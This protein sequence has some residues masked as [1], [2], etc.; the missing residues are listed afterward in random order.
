M[1]TRPEFSKQRDC[2][3]VTDYPVQSEVT[4]DMVW[5]SASHLTLQDDLYRVGIKYESCS[6]TYLSYE[7]PTK[8]NYDWKNSF[9]K[10]HDLE[11]F[12]GALGLA[13]EL[14][15]ELEGSKDVWVCDKLYQEYKALLKQ[16]KTVNPKLLIVIGKWSLFFLCRNVT[17]A[18]TISTYKEPRPFGGLTTYRSSMLEL[19][20]STQLKSILVIPAYP[21]VVIFK[22]PDRKVIYT[23]DLDKLGVVF[24]KLKGGTSLEHY[25]HVD[26]ELNYSDNYAYLM[27]ALE[28]IY[29]QVDSKVTKLAMDIETRHYAIDCI[30]LC[31]EKDVSL[32]IPFSSYSEPCLHTWEEEVNLVNKI[33][34]ILGHPNAKIVGQN[35]FYDSAYLSKFWLFDTCSFRDTMITNHVIYNYLPK[36]LDFLA[37]FY[38]D[39]YTYWKDMASHTIIPVTID[40]VDKLDEIRW[41]YNGLDCCYTYAIAY[42]QEEL[43]GQMPMKFLEFYKFQ[44]EDLTPAISRVMKRGVRVDLAKKQELYT[45]LKTLM[46][47]ARDKLCWLI[48]EEWN[49]NSTPQIRSIFID[50]LRVNPVINKKSLTSTF[51]SDAMLV[52]L[53]NYPDYKV[54]LI[55][56]LEYRSLK[57]FVS[58]FLGAEVDDDNRMRSSYNIAGTSTYRLAS[59]KNQFGTG[60]NLQNVPS[61]GKIDLRYALQNVYVA[62]EIDEETVVDS[63]EN[64]TSITKLPNCKQLFIPDEGYTF[65]DVDFAGAD[66]R[67]M[68]YSANCSYLIDIFEDP[69]KD[70]YSTM[71]SVYYGRIIHK[72]DKE[73]QIFK[74]IVHASNY[75]GHATTLS[76]KAGL[77]VHEVERVQK[78][79]FLNCPEIVRLQ[80]KIKREVKDRG[81]IENIFGARGYFLDYK[82]KMLYNKAVAW[83][84]SSPISILTNKGLVNIDKEAESLKKSIYTVHKI[85]PVEVLLQVHDSLAGQYKSSDITAPQ[86]IIRHMELELPYEVPL[87]I[88]VGIKTSTL[89][90]GD[91]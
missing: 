48:G 6:Y 47:E 45:K 27:E 85:Q 30:G 62:T 32:T 42:E 13:G 50:L 41:E 1:L 43:I 77:L 60:M 53:E 73:R 11:P 17:V 74:A 44:Q 70:L 75:L 55:L 51:G 15:H 64:T 89:S 57:I 5:S 86:R 56:L 46:D 22:H 29:I 26:R 19:H 90:Y 59:R 24:K 66:A 39:E 9:A 83:H 61:K 23:T 10:Y 18:K 33:K 65:F 3:I 36:S 54:F 63:I 81:F 67:I 49:P 31:I 37:S 21:S 28:D 40:R 12:E 20:E 14:F 68:A 34:D 82:D 76:A 71:A 91:C 35:Y 2:M 52:Y 4:S 25:I 8:E 72:T 80:N 79:Y 78:W 38:I 84:G 16:I 58:T 88:P 69:A 7:R 87:T